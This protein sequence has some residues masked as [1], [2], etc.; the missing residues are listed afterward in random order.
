MTDVSSK[1]G[2]EKTGCNI[3]DTWKLTP[4]ASEKG[5]VKKPALKKEVGCQCSFE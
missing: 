5:D 3:L 1:H 4:N 2:V